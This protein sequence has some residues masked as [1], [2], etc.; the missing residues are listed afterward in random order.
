MIVHMAVVAIAGL[1]TIFQAAA[2]GLAALL[3]G[4]FLVFA[5]LFGNRP[6]L[7]ALGVLYTGLPAVALIWLH[8]DVPYGVPVR[9]SMRVRGRS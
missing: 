3:V 9:E 5:L 2:L 7:P 1:L 6:L 4:T 8:A